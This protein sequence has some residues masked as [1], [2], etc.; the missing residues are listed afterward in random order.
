MSMKVA[1][2]IHKSENRLFYRL[3]QGDRQA[4]CFPYLGG[5]ANAFGK[6]AS[7]LDGRVELWAAN[8]PGHGGSNA[9]LVEDIDDL[10]EGYAMEV[11]KII[12]P[13][14]VFLGHSMGGTVAYFLA[15]RLAEGCGAGAAGPSAVIISACGAPSIFKD[16]QYSRLPGRELVE[17]IMTYGAMPKE[18]LD[19]PDFLEALLPVFRA[20]YRVLE[21]AAQKDPRPLGTPTYLLWGQKDDAVPLDALLQWKKYLKHGPIVWPIKGAEHM[22]IHSMAD[23][24]ARCVEQSFGQME[25]C[26]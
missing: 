16:I 10:V 11:S 20:D 6:L 22:F 17:K 1:N 9:A 12:R 25:E 21:S 24:V 2:S 15:R 19:E 26:A 4:I 14:C 8:P 5:Y 3:S 23:E 7:L 18:V 13:E